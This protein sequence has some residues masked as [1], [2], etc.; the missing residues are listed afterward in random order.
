MTTIIE[1]HNI[2]TTAATVD[3][4]RTE[5]LV[6]RLLGSFT[7]GTEL[8]TVE[9]GRRLGLYEALADRG[10]STAAELA[11]DAGIAT[12]YASEWL[13]QQAHA[14]FVDAYG[15]E[16]AEGARRF[17]LPAEFV[18]VL[19]DIDHPAH[20][21]GT[22]PLLLGVAKTLPAVAD[23]Y[24]TSSGVEYAA[25]G[26]ELRFG[27]ASLNRPGF[28]GA[29]RSWFE[30][31]PD[32][33]ERLD[34]GGT[35]LDAGCGVGWSSIGLA[36][37]FPNT[38][39]VGIDLDEKS[40]EEARIHVAEAG[41]AD[42]VQ[43]LHGNATDVAALRSAGPEG[44]DAVAVFQALHDM[45]EPA[46]AL[47]AFRDVLSAGGTVLIADEHGGDHPAIPAE[48][49]RVQRAMSVL[50]CT[51]ATWAESDAVVNGTVLLASTLSDWRTEA[52]FERFEI[53]PVEHPFWTFYR[54]G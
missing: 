6:E 4:A 37:A 22:A 35:V 54:L 33:V 40:V 31:M 29:T 45:G 53:L 39:V 27:I 20:L 50:H 43:I 49:G 2:A 1:D 23:A 38:R 21:I 13:D 14:G 9:L 42:R 34:A 47:A 26:D 51:P 41:L 10:P 18:P 19:L 8:L 5:A 7:L 11:A 16:D 12:R 36:R 24:A 48:I 28:I 32:V 3:P 17:V 25:F 44:Y 46:R 30:T 15:S 52:G